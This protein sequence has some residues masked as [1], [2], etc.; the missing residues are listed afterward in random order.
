MGETLTRE[1]VERIVDFV[2]RSWAG[3]EYREAKTAAMADE[4]G[5]HDAAQRRA[6]DG[7]AEA[8]N[9]A[10]G[11]AAKLRDLLRRVMDAPCDTSD[12]QY[13]ERNVRDAMGPGT[14]GKARQGNA[15]ADLLAEVDAAVGGK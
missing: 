3:V 9:V 4:L 13:S 5:Q 15:N 8:L 11:E 10:R 6:V 2:R 12:G 1:E 7:Q 14:N